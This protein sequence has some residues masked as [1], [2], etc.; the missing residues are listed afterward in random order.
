MNIEVTNGWN[1]DLNG[2]FKNLKLSEN[3]LGVGGC[4]YPNQVLSA[5]RIFAIPY[6]MNNSNATETSLG[7]VGVA[8][9]GIPVYNSFEDSEETATYGRIFFNC[10]EHP[11]RN[12][13][14]HYHEYPTCLRLISD[15]WK[16]EKEKCDEID[17][18]LVAKGHSPLT[19]SLPMVG[20]STAQWYGRMTTVRRVSCSRAVTPA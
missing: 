8:L 13:V 6:T 4:N 5:G 9:N 14:Y 1:T 3:N 2:G 16:S 12:W 19:A 7:T 17:A 10:C 11:Q 15:N 20:Q 18:L